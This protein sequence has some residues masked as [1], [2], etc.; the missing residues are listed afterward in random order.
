MFSDLRL[1]E[2][3]LVG[4]RERE[5]GDERIGLTP[6]DITILSL[7]LGLDFFSSLQLRIRAAIKP[8]Q[9]CMSQTTTTNPFLLSPLQRKHL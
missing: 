8:L 4:L 2:G 3:V 7:C 6:T 1:W 5:V 9:M